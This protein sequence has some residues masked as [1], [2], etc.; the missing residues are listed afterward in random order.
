MLLNILEVLLFGC[1]MALKYPSIM[2]FDLL[3]IFLFY[4][5]HLIPLLTVLYIKV[6]YFNNN[7]SL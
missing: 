6:L 1:L 5:E 2:N 4:Y 3:N 7:H